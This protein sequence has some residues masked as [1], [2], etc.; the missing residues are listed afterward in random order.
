MSTFSRLLVG[1]C[2]GGLMVPLASPA[3][4]APA[5]D[6]LEEVIVTAN[7]VA[8]P[9]NKVA[10]SI[11]V[12]TSAE[13]ESS[14][15]VDLQDL[16]NHVP[17]VSSDFAGAP[18]TA[19]FAVRGISAGGGTSTTTG[20]YIDDVSINFGNFGFAGAFE[21]AFF[22]MDRIEVLRGPQGTLY[23]AESF[24][25]TIRFVN[26]APKLGATEGY[27]STD[28]Y[29]Q[30]KGSP[31]AGAHGA[32]NLP[33]APDL[34]LRIAGL[35]QSDGGF[36]N[37]VDASGKTV[38][39]D[40]NS[41]TI[42]GAR[43]SLLWQPAEGVKINPLV[44][45]QH[46]GNGDTWT[47]DRTLGEYNSP[48]LL[49]EPLQDY[50][51]L[52]AL[53]ASFEFG[54]H[55]L[56]SV[57]SYVNREIDRIQDYTIY[58]VGYVAPPVV[59]YYNPA[60]PAAALATLESVADRAFHT[61]SNEQYSEEVRLSSR[62]PTLGLTTL[63]GLFLNHEARG[64]VSAEDAAGFG[65]TTTQLFGVGANDA[66]NAAGPSFGFPPNGADLGDVLYA[67]N[68]Q[69]RFNR[70]AVYGEA[71]YEPTDHLQGLK[72]TAGVRYSR[73]TEKRTGFADGFFN[74]GYQSLSAGFDENQTAPKFR[75]SYQVNDDT[76]VY[77][78]AAKGFRLGGQNSSLPLS[79]A[80]ELQAS[81]L[82]F[83]PDYQTDSLWSYEAGAKVA[84]ADHRLQLNVSAFHIDWTNIV[85]SINFQV[86][87]FGF[88]A[89][90]GKATS[91]GGDLS[92]QW[93]AA[94][95]L[96]LDVGVAY[97]NALFNHTVVIDGSPSS[98]EIP[99]NVPWSGTAGL[100]YEWAIGQG[101]AYARGEYLYTDVS[102]GD[103]YAS[104]INF[105]RPAYSTL[106]ASAGY[107]WDRWDLTLYGKN[108]TDAHPPLQQDI[109]LGY[110]N[111][112]T[113]RPRQI[114]LQLHLSF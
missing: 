73:I 70:V 66:L 2:A 44:Q 104:G 31:G 52:A 77:L 88:N 22:D 78:S 58:D 28:A 72:L 53:T 64:H 20:M 93:R 83:A 9:L 107:K 65:A 56:T 49:N 91:N 21:P 13:L 101:R 30:S 27:V 54:H 97:T 108:L 110:Y 18:G 95:G 40:T 94:P 29:L 4:T 6:A 39:T 114:G 47:Y 113:M 43:V 19:S 5:T 69:L 37:H 41:Q 51:R 14:R 63:V 74:G 82:S 50:F 92:L 60:D 11:G 15:S 10:A 80:A 35:Y 38:R 103:L 48:R 79:C 34:A 61:N 84:S 42:T 3:A 96:D 23:G 86:C 55:T 85:Q 87:G 17:G 46:T 36:I 45:Y 102:R 109:G 98:S 75:A 24:G 57:T 68:S 62:F 8:E 7:K 81:G 90:F 32:I 1:V 71:S 99:L 89:N 106:G 33:L 111:V 12:M 26:S 76:L 16:V 59:A 105:I 100:R 25:G 112:A 67:E